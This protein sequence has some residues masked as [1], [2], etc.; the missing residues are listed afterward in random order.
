MRLVLLPLLLLLACRQT[1]DPLA[2]SVTTG[3]LASNTGG[4]EVSASSDLASSDAPVLP[5]D[6][7]ALDTGTDAGPPPDVCDPLAPRAVPA[8]VYALPEAG[9]APYV[10]V[11]Q[12]ATTDIRVTAYLMGYG[13]ILDTLTAK[14]KAGVTVRVILDQGQDAN[15]KYYE[16]LTQAGIECKWSDPKFSYYHPKFMVVDGARATVST[17]NYSKAYSV[18]KERNFVAQIDDPSDVAD[19]ITIFDADWAGTAP[20][21]DCTRLLVSPD[22]SKERLLA[23]IDS[24]QTSIDIESMQLAEKDMR[25]HIA[26]RKAAGVAVRA[27]LAAPSWIDA[28]A[29]AAKFL[30]SHGIEA[31]WMSKPGVH[32]KA[33]V[34]DGTR[35]YLGSQNFSW[36]SLTKNREVGVLL[37]EPDAV[38]VMSTTFEKDWAA[39]TKF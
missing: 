9:E 1:T 6:A 13:V 33:I 28:N 31:R 27:V 11:L 15:K 16:A 38:K 39:S 12:T 34:V 32:V 4:V 29:D 35:A 2:A 14:A 36:T 22:N 24:A 10:D 7:A 17:G 19:L 23:F 37:T 20:N 30:A 25:D 21:V 26:K 18:E 8:R 3:D 5:A